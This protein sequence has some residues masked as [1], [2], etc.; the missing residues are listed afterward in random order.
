[1]ELSMNYRKTLTTLAFLA[2]TPFVNAAEHTVKMLTSGSDGQIMVM[3]PGFLKIASGDTVNFVPSDPTHNA[4]S[5]ISPDG[6]KDFSTP[7]GIETKVVFDQEGVYVYKC[8]P[9]QALGMFG[10][11][12]VGKAVNLAQAKAGIEALKPAIAMNKERLDQY[13]SKVE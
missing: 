10:I 12:Q 8:T 6:A 7:L 1:M 13:L 5:S 4:Q 9:H 11:I 3:E 2:C